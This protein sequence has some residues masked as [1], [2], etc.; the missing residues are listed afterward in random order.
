MTEERANPWPRE[1]FMG[2][3]EDNH[4]G[5][6]YAVLSEAATVAR[7]EGDEERDRDFHKY[8]DGDIFDS[9][10]KYYAARFEA[11]DATIK[12]LV[13]ALEGSVNWI[14]EEFESRD[15]GFWDA[16][17]ITEVIAARKALAAH[18]ETQEKSE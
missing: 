13:E 12:Q 5:S 14:V 17:K 3:L 16:E 7:W 4:N 18:R 11:K 9:Q 8:V 2:E 1:I 10:A 15:G 6:A